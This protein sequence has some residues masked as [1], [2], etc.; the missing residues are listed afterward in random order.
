M[1]K[2]SIKAP[3]ISRVT[4]GSTAVLDLPIGPTYESIKFTNTGTALAISH[5]GKI[6]VLAEGQELQSYNNLQELIDINAYYGR[7]ADTAN[8]FMIHAV[9]KEFGDLAYQRTP[10]WGTQG[11]ATL[12]IEIDLPVGAPANITMAAQVF[13]DT[14][15]Q[16]LGT[17][18]RVRNFPYSSPVSGVVEIDKLPRNGE[19]YKAIHMFK[20]DITNVLLTV[21]QNQVIDSSKALLERDQKN[22]RPVARVPQTA[23]ATHLDFLLDGDPGDM[24]A[25]SVVRN[26]K[27]ELINDFRLAMTLGS[28]GS[29]SIITECISVWGRN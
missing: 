6:R 10:A 2:K 16:P 29:V 18:I 19:V 3:S 28:A 15:P 13:I 23:K 26:G 9:A 24:L 8:E 11:L 5:F 20:S 7:S 27:Q 14:V 4:P 1:A 17:Y 25:T 22:V 21:N 12:T